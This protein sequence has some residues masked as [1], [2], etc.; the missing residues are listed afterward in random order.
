VGIITLLFIFLFPVVSVAQ[1]APE[2]P[3]LI[4]FTGSF[5][6]IDEAKAGE[7]S[8]LMVSIKET[9]W[10]LRIAKVEK[11][12]GRDPS[13]TRLLE[14]LFPRQI[15][16]TGPEHLLNILRDPRIAGTAM[17]LEGRLYVG[18]RMFFL[19]TITDSFS[20]K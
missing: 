19:T 6:P 9:K 14:S 1:V 15:Q 12:S 16:I 4:R 11:L 17:T 7:L 18:E 2:P 3:P 10:Y 13:G 5:L 8:S 20:T